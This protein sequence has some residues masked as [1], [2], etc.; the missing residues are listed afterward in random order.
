MTGLRRQAILFR[1]KFLKDFIKG[2][3]RIF[4]HMIVAALSAAIALSLPYTIRFIAKNLLIYWSL[5]GNEKIF[6]IVV[7]LALALL[8][9][10]LSN[11]ISRSLREKKLSNMARRAGLVSVSPTRGLFAWRKNKKLKEQVGFARDVLVIGST[12]FRTFVDSKG[13]LHNVVQDCREAKIMF[14]NP[15]SQGASARAKSILDPNITLENFR[16]QIRKS[17]DFLKSLK[18]VQK[19]VRLKLYQDL[20]LLKLTIIGDYV[21]IQHYHAGLDVQTM[22]EYVFKHDQNTGSLYTPFYQYFLTRWNNPDIP[23]YDLDTD[24]LIY[25]DETGN[26]VKRGKFDEIERG[27]AMSA[28]SS[29]HPGCEN[30]HQEETGSP[31]LL[32]PFRACA[33]TQDI[34]TEPRQGLPGGLHFGGKEYF[35]L[36]S[37]RLMC[38]AIGWMSV[39]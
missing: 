1:T 21:W 5:I 23:E 8:V 31:L 28:G 16:D 2:Q 17:I 35:L 39:F 12:G 30:H 15:Y 38:A 33:R 10:F 20:P 18:A 32:P 4:Y 13:D 27:A 34:F 14:L 7:E 37:N 26:E 36:K 6:V 29:I 25:R 9:I 11:Y 24:E 19:N 3:S 22:P